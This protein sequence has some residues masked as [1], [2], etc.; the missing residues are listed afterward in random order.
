MS[1]LENQKKINKYF[2]LLFIIIKMER[3]LFI[4]ISESYRDGSGLLLVEDIYIRL[5]NNNFIKLYLF[6]IAAGI[7][8]FITCVDCMADTFR[9]FDQGVIVHVSSKDNPDQTKLI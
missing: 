8:N 2:V 7:T 5:F 9:I 3:A 1:N 6:D 4:K